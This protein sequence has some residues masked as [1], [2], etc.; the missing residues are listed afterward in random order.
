MAAQDRCAE[1]HGALLQQAFQPALRHW[2]NVQ[3]A[4]YQAEFEGERPEAKPRWPHYAQPVAME[5]VASLQ[6]QD[7]PPH[8]AVPFW[9]LCRL[10]G[11]VEDDR[12]DA[13]GGELAGEQQTGRPGA[14][15]DHVVEGSV[16]L[17]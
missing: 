10:G 13:R 2:E 14:D 6:L 3:W 4:A 9:G 15:D 7:G 16:S 11:A 5:Q 8:D 12:A 1:P 17:S